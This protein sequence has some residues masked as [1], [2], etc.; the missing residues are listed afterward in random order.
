MGVFTMVPSIHRLQ[1]V[2]RQGVAK[3]RLLAA[4]AIFAAG[5]AL[6]LCFWNNRP[7]VQTLRVNFGAELEYP[8]EV[9]AVMKDEAAKYGLAL[10]FRPLGAGDDPLHQVASGNLDVAIVRGGARLQHPDLCQIACFHG[11]PLH[12]FVRAEL[13]AGGLAVLK[14]KRLDLGPIH[15]GTHY[16]AETVL[17]H[18]GWHA[19]R[20]Y[21]ELNHS[22]KEL[23][24]LPPHEFPDAVFCAVKLLWPQGQSLV[25]KYNLRLV[26]VP[27]GDVL[28]IRN[29]AIED[30]CIPAYTYGI[31]PCVPEKPIHTVAA[32]SLVMVNAR[33]PKA[34][35][36]RWLTV[37]YESDFSR[38]VG[39][40]ST[41]P[42]ALERGQEYPLHPGAIEYLHRN[43]PWLNRQLLDQVGNLRNFL[44]SAASALILIW[45]WYRR[46]C[47]ERFDQYLRT[48]SAWEIEAWRTFR[49]G[50]LNQAERQNL[51]VQLV[52]LE[53][54][55]LEKHR[56][57]ILTDEQQLVTFLGRVEHARQLL[58][59]VSRLEWGDQAA[60]GVTSE[61]HLKAA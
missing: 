58:A 13:A 24:D 34:A 44:V 26:E 9:A 12:L 52:E 29:R 59:D 22:Y 53:I 2:V 19:G 27:L 45:T 15:A 25:K 30:V 51:L 28:S 21:H 7:T 18:L 42:A 61:D 14:G 16:L 47:V 38:R 56:S 10:D 5:L 49:R 35:I 6:F 40:T 23:L 54:E 60:A 55:A 17:Q 41:D 50:G 4:A 36:V 48:V 8:A 39:K 31:E 57:G 43:D 1:R 3:N 11:Q 46:R 37:L 33:T 32:N 20:D